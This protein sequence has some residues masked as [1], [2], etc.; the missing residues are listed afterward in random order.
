MSSHL[1]GLDV[2]MRH[3][4]QPRIR[5]R[6]ACWLEGCPMGTSVPQQVTPCTLAEVLGTSWLSRT[7]RQESLI[8]CSAQNRGSASVHWPH[9]KGWVRSQGFPS[10]PPV[11]TGPGGDG[12]AL[13]WSQELVSL[14]GASRSLGQ[15]GGSQEP[16]RCVLLLLPGTYSCLFKPPCT[17]QPIISE[18]LLKPEATACFCCAGGGDCSLGTPREQSGRR[19]GER[20]LLLWTSGWGICMSLFIAF[21]H[22]LCI[23]SGSTTF[24]ACV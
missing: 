2:D 12:G 24:Q 17:A 20:G 19:S 14:W 22:S 5:V 4:L 15:V 8:S 7:G 6:K 13:G 18:N 23:Y 10:P 1:C 11:C 9:R 16:D 3:R 21:I